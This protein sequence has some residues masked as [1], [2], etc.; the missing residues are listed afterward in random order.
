MRT[1]RTV[2][3]KKTLLLS[4]LLMAG[5]ALAQQQPSSTVKQGYCAKS[6]EFALTPEKVSFPGVGEKTLYGWL[7]KPKGRGPFPAVIWNHGS[8]SMNDPPLPFHRKDLAT[9]YVS[10]GYVFFTPHRAGHGLSKDAG[11]PII[12]KEEANCVGADRAEIR[13]C[14][15]RYHEEANLDV[16]AAVKWLQAQPFIEKSRVAVTGVSYGGI[17]TILTAEK[18]IRAFVPFAPAAMS[19]VNLQLRER[20]LDAIRKAQS[21]IFLIQAEGDYSTGPSELLGGYLNQKGGLNKAKLYPRFG[22]TQQDAHSRFATT[23]QGIEIW[24]K[25]V[26]A[27][28]K[29]AMK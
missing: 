8:G 9:L 19:W 25:D 5:A 28:L 22:T 27:F 3:M 7:Y 2:L 1:K 11:V 10:N 14:K 12:E 21:P 26:L 18:G 4:I 6:S 16:V 13:R 15:V 23:C 24:G 17:Q 20:L 29:S